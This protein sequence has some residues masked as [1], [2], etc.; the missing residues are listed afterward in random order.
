M[1]FWFWLCANATAGVGGT[2]ELGKKVDS[3]VIT[4]VRGDVRVR[5]DGDQKRNSLVATD[6]QSNTACTLDID[7][8]GSIARV[9]FKP[10]NEGDKNNCT[11]DFA[12]NLLPGTAFSIDLEEGMLDTRALREPLRATVGT[13]QAR[14]ADQQGDL[15]LRMGSGDVSLEGVGKLKVTTDTGNIRGTWSGVTEFKTSIGHVEMTALDGPCIATA[16][17]G[18]IL[19]TFDKLPKEDLSFHSAKGNI[20]LDLPNGQPIKPGLM[21]TGGTSSCEVPEGGEIDVVAVT[22]EGSIRVF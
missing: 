10:M 15:D 14:I 1:L 18:N 20:V 16:G 3:V 7:E 11:M 12:V 9:T 4:S 5:I 13:G 2:Y 21:A 19:L 22:G 17:I 6:R 8:S